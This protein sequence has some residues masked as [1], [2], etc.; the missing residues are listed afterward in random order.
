MDP[1][2]Q[3][4]RSSGDH[5][6]SPWPWSPPHGPRLHQK[7]RANRSINRFRPASA[8]SVPRGR[9]V[10]GAARGREREL[11]ASGRYIKMHRSNSRSVWGRSTEGQT[12]GNGII[13]FK[14]NP[15]DRL[16]SHEDENPGRS[17]RRFSYQLEVHDQ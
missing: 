2:P 9:G 14:P 10:R 16:D 1:L 11:K 12:G 13:K 15:H 6:L 5:M 7:G 4:W 3:A 8:S 17:L